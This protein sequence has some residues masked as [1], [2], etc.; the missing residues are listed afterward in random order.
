MKAVLASHVKGHIMFDLLHDESKTYL[1]Q[2]ADNHTN[3][4]RFKYAKWRGRMPED[5]DSDGGCTDVENENN[6]RVKRRRLNGWGICSTFD[7]Y[8]E[9]LDCSDAWWPTSAKSEQKKMYI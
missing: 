8:S 3:K 6:K 1:R 9:R 5:D 4:K 7:C 2:G